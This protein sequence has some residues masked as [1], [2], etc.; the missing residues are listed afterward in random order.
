[1]KT[2][3]SIKGM[4]CESCKIL[5]EEVCAEI[6]GVKSCIVDVKKG[7]VIIDHDKADVNAIKIEIEKLGKYK[8]TI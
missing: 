2:M 3:L 4:H 5:I 7:T 1:M 6:K 8:V